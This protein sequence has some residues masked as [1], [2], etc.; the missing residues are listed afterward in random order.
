MPRITPQHWKRLVK[1]Y[2]LCNFTVERET[3]DHIVLSKKDVL[4]P[5]IVP[6]YKEIGLDII[7]SNNRTAGL[8]NEEFL[9]LL[10]RC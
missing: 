8:S 7:K 9:D 1:V 5:I 3:D 10:N 2:K 4:R 6:K